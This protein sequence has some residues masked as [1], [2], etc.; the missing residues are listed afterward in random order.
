[1]ETLFSYLDSLETAELVIYFTLLSLIL[2]VFPFSELIVKYLRNFVSP[3]ELEI[4]YFNYHTQ[5]IENLIEISDEPIIPQSS[6]NVLLNGSSIH[7]IWKVK[8]ALKIDLLPIGENLKGNASTDIING[9]KKKY[10]L[11]A[12]GFN[13]KKIE[14]VIDL[15][16][17]IFY[18]IKTN[19]LASN[20]KIIRSIPKI[21]S[22]KFSNSKA[23][24]CK[25]TGTKSHKLIS[26]LRTSLLDIK[27]NPINAVYFVKTSSKKTML[28]NSISRGK[29]L[30]SYTF[31]TKKYQ[32]LN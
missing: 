6:Q 23:L 26:W 7:F 31:S 14:S 30:K 1:M 12:H 32:S 5:K 3:T 20:Q 10:T 29:I 17:E 16:Q 2:A 11:V 15:S 8:G 18:S 13:G 27:T 4:L 24:N 22:T 25:L 9:N 19:P 28:T 21:G